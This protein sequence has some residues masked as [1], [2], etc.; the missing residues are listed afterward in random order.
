MA[1][2]NGDRFEWIEHRFMRLKEW[3]SLTA[4]E[5]REIHEWLA[6]K[7]RKVREW[8]HYGERATYVSHFP[9]DTPARIGGTL[10]VGFYVTIRAPWSLWNEQVSLFVENVND[11]DEA[12]WTANQ[13]LKQIVANGFE[14]N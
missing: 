8:K 6:L 7:G 2:S 5:K 3:R 11:E 9:V 12:V 13:W 4:S 10:N 14:S 1:Y